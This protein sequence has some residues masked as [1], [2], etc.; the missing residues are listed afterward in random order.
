MLVAYESVHAIRKRKRKRKKP[1]CAVKLDIMKAYDRVEWIFLERSLERFGF[2]HRWIGMIMRC[3]RSARFSV[4]LNGGFSRSF[5]PSRGLRQGDPLSPYLFL[6]C[7]EGFSAFLKKA[8]SENQIK[9]VNF[10]GTGPMLHTFSLL[11]IV[12]FFW[13]VHKLIYIHSRLSGC[14]FILREWSI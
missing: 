2:S 6:F 5:L 9:S 3:V 13:K 12:W 1:L 7:V 8:Q 14:L 4:K 10:G 11:M